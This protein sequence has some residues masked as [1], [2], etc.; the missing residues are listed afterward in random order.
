[1]AEA[2]DRDQELKRDQEAEKRA[3]VPVPYRACLQWSSFFHEPSALKGLTTAQIL[4]HIED[5]A[6][7]DT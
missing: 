6:L 7:R 5:Q 3:K 2:R 1:M 4:P